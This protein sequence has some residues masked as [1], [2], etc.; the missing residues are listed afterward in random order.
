MSLG[1]RQGARDVAG[2]DA[3]DEAVAETVGHARAPRPSVSKDSATRPDRRSPR[4]RRTLAARPGRKWSARRN[5]RGRALRTTA[6]EAQPSLPSRG[7]PRYRPV[8]LACCSSETSGPRSQSSS[9]GPTVSLAARC[10]KPVEKLLADRSMQQEPRRGR[11][12]LAAIAEGAVERVEGGPVEIGIREARSSDSCRR[13]PAPPASGHV[14][15]RHRSCARSRP[16]R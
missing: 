2:V 3:G 16:I 1:R 10:A 14:P 9:P 15:R 6:A 7:P 5:S 11:A 12:D 13:V 8:T 4:G